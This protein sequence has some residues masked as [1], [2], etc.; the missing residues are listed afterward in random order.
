MYINIHKYTQIYINMI[1]NRIQYTLRQILHNSKLNRKNYVKNKKLY[2]ELSIKNNNNS[3]IVRRRFH[4]EYSKTN[5]IP[6]P[7][8]NNN[9]Y[10]IL[11]ILIIMS[12]VL[13][14]QNFK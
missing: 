9:N 1:A 11:K 4:S 10:E 5:E 2:N 8:N 13:F 14:Q 3:L 12:L 6:K 7:P